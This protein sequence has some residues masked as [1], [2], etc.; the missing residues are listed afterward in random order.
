MAVRMDGGGV[1]RSILAHP[2]FLEAKTVMAYWAIAGEID[3][4]PVLEEALA[5][6]KRLLLPRCRGEEMTA[7]RVT[8]LTPLR[9]GVLGI[10]EPGEETEIVP[11]GEIDLI[12]VP[13]MAYDARGRRLGRGKGYYD[14]FLPAAGGRTI[15]VSAVL[16]EHVPV[17]DH[18]VPVDAVAGDH[19]VILCGSEDEVCW[20]RETS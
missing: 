14:R 2:W 8:D 18:D 1:C 19:G 4:G 13:A 16:L 7:R 5:R 10:P 6:G 9:P 17:E 11:P 3:L 12:L 15:G 20:T